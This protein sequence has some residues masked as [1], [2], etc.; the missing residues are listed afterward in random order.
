[1][2]SNNPANRLGISHTGRLDVRVPGYN[3]EHAIAKVVAAFRPA[4]P[5][6][7]I[8]I[9][10][11]NWAGGTVAAARLLAFLPF[12]GGFILDTVWRGRHENCLAMRCGR[13]TAGELNCA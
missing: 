7:A 3:E 8:H 2:S 4:L 5:A 12:A 1:M 13:G 9:Y 6:A 11:K 10:D